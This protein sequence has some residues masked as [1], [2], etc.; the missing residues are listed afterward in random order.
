MP[1]SGKEA[2]VGIVSV[3]ASFLGVG[4]VF[5]PLMEFTLGREAFD[6]I[7]SQEK[8]VLLLLNQ[9]LVTA[10]GLSIIHSIIRKYRPLPVD[11]LSMD[12]RNPFDKHDGWAIWGIAGIVA[13]PAFVYLASVI[14]TFFG[15]DNLA[16][17]GTVDTVSDMLGLDTLTFFSLMTTTSV[18]A[19]LFEETLFRGFLLPS[20]AQVMPVPAAVALSSLAFSLA[21]LSPRDAPQLLA[22]GMLLGLVYIRSK[23]L[24]SPIVVHGV[25]NGTVIAI[26]Y[27]LQSQGVD[28]ARLL[29][30]GGI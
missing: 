2:A 26:L 23:N 9:T 16:S 4:L 28:I 22:L 21:H 3:V 29:H 10:I 20:L 17:P 25:W 18:L 15:M 5:I 11:V 14:S 30:E 24:L 1:W 27:F 7:S 8:S 6:N 12:W 19:P 13:S